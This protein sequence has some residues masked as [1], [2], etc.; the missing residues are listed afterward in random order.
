MSQGHPTKVLRVIA[1]YKFTKALLVVLTGLGLL[2][3]L[4]PLFQT[5]LYEFVE[6]L[7]RYFAPQML[8]HWLDYLT[9]LSPIRIRWFSAVS[10]LYASLFVTEGIGLW[11]GWR[12]AEWLTVLMTGS[13]IPLEIFE[14]LANPTWVRL[15]IMLGNFLIFG[16]LIW[17]IRREH[18]N[19]QQLD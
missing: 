4:H 15:A 13:L 7:P 2:N 9:N 5:K 8:H 12:W 19:G 10:F 16:Y 1:L 14:L 17:L 11:A 3:L 18:F 6:V